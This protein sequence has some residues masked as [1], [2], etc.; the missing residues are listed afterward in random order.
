MTARWRGPA[1]LVL[2]G[3]PGL[4][5]LLPILPEVPGV[6]RL[7][8]LANPFLLLVLAAFAGGWAA[9]RC[10]FRLSAPGITAGRRLGEIAAG[11][12]L[13]LGIAVLDHAARGWWQ[14]AP[15][16]P[17]SVVEGWSPAVLLAGLLYGG[18]V[19]EVLMRW[20]VMS[21]VVLALWR[22]LAR[23]AAAPP[24]P[25]L[26]AGVAVAAIVFAAAHLPALAADAAALA[27][28]PVLRGLALNTL[29]G[30][31]FGWMFLRRDLVAAMAAHAGLHLGFAVVAQAA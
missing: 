9:R 3:L 17:P 5:S 6:P 19:E 4:L 12:A 26:A 15:G 1:L 29:A 7:V 13:G 18:V 2:A 22:V 11:V 31:V 21:L 8:L 10:G 20:G 24:G 23:H 16:V 14:A 27:P 30:L 28:G 25:V